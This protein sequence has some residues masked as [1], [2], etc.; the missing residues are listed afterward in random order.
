MAE[1]TKSKSKGKRSRNRSGAAA[2][3]RDGRSASEKPEKYRFAENVG[4]EATVAEQEY[5]HYVSAHLDELGDDPDVLLDVPVVKVDKI[6]LKLEDLQAHVALKAQVLDLVSLEVGVDAHLGKVEIDIEGVEAQA[7]LKV[8]LDHVA[9]IVDRVMTTI[10]RNPE[11]VKGLGH[12]IEDVGRGAGDLVGEAGEAVEHVGEGAE[13]TLPE[14]GRGAGSAVEQVGEGA[15]QAVGDVGQGAGEA[16][17]DVGE[18]A[19]QAVG[20]VGEGAGQAVGD[21]GQ[22]AGQ[23]VG[24]AGQGASQLTSAPKVAKDSAKDV[25]KTVA[26]E[27]GAAAS[28]E[29][30]DL[31]QA[32]TRKVRKLGDRRRKRRAEKHPATEAAQR[33]AEEL[34]IDIGAIEGSGVQGLVTV[35]DVKRAANGQ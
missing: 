6:Y 22:G 7:L 35:K 10:D 12:A 25:A 2:S 8:R 16:V 1:R 26:E 3:R 27:V 24:E 33:Q 23:A 5:R 28:E 11:L 4:G 17:G 18:G 30:K 19:G 13:Q 9:A 14:V 21:I 15:G 32:A 34:G 29:A 31:G 20:D